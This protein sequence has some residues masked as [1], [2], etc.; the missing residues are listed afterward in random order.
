[1]VIGPLQVFISLE[2]IVDPAAERARLKKA[3]DDQTAD[4]AK[5]EAKLANEKFVSR[6]PAEVV[7]RERHRV[8]EARERIDKLQAQYRSLA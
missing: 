6:A 8:A 2:G 5:S 7:D 4:L 3:I 1:M